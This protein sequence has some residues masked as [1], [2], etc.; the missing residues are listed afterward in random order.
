MAWEA[1][2][3]CAALISVDRDDWLLIIHTQWTLTL[4][5]LLSCRIPW[6]SL[7]TKRGCCDSMT[8]RRS[9][10][11]SA[12]RWASLLS[13]PPLQPNPERQCMHAAYRDWD[14][15]PL[16]LHWWLLT[17]KK[18]LPTPW[19]HRCLPF[20]SSVEALQKRGHPLNNVQVE[21]S[22]LCPLRRGGESE[23]KAKLSNAI[24]FSRPLH[25]QTCLSEFLQLLWPASSCE[26]VILQH[27]FTEKKQII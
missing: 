18:M 22:D 7:Q 6:I 16:Q 9:G 10:N 15:H 8:T 27:L 5:P 21:Q 2:K 25:L 19:Q 12:T 3:G 11:S 23:V 14:R 24:F 20:L 13:C 26:K 4:F 17:L 1:N